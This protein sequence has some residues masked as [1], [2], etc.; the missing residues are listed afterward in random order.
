MTSVHERKEGNMIKV[1]FEDDYARDLLKNIL[2]EE[3]WVESDTPDENG[4][5]V[6]LTSRMGDEY[7]DRPGVYLITYHGIFEP[8]D[9]S[10][11][12]GFIYGGKFY[13]HEFAMKTCVCMVGR[14]SA[15]FWK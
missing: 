6:I 8:S 12:R 2:C 10:L 9:L 4:L 1:R 7:Y 15:V 3:Y 5:L 14:P 13:D 11:I